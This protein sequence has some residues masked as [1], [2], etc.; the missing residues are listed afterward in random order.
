MTNQTGRLFVCGAGDLKCAVQ[1]F[2]SEGCPRPNGGV[3]WLVKPTAFP[4]EPAGYA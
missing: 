3:V 1:T 4:V 2:T